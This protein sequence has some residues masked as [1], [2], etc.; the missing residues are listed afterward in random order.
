M[1]KIDKQHKFDVLVDNVIRCDLCERMRGKP[2]V[3]TYR[4]GNIN[5]RV[6]FVGEAI[7]SLIK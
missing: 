7:F 5:A 2:K 3:L 1:L 4:N 6:V